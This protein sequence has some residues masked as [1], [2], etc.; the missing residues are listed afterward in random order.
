MVES[1]SAPVAVEALHGGE[2]PGAGGRQ[3]GLKLFRQVSSLLG[4]RAAVIALT[5]LTSLIVARAVGPAAKGVLTLLSSSVTLLS[6]VV[7]LGFA[8]GGVHLYKSRNYSPGTI[9]G[10]SLV[11][12]MASLCVIA[13]MLVAGGG[14]ITRTFGGGDGREV[15]TRQW[16]WLS[17]ATLPAMLVSTLVQAVMLVDNRM[18]VYA[19]STIGSQLIGFGAA[20]ALVVVYGWGI[21]GA[22]VA[23]LAGHVC[24]LI[25]SLLWLRSLGEPGALR[26]PRSAFRPILQASGGP[27][28]NSLLA[29][30]FKHGEGILLALLLDLRSVGHFGVALAFYQLLTEAPRAIVW[31]LVGRMTDPGAN[32]VE[33]AA[34]SLRLVPIAMILPVLLMAA[35]SP[36]VIPLVY[37]EAFSPAGTLLAFM[38][39]GV[40][41]RAVS[42]VVYAYFVVVGG[43]DKI[44]PCVGATAVANLVLDVLLAPRWGLTGVAVSNV[45][46]EF[47]LA[48]LSVIVFLRHSKA[49]LSS[50]LL[51]KS[52]FKGLAQQIRQGVRSWK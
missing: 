16:L 18:R 40:I 7:G 29:N 23:T 43:L 34:R 14:A 11:F 27:Y 15:L 36:F 30:V 45:I 19:L 35:V 33:V 51:R 25:V 13:M 22:L 49:P 52:D 2:V 42:L 31:P 44:A 8:A 38:S 46:A 50:I 39:P 28:L 6:V 10:V 48:S 4:A 24:T 3:P 12:W 1:G 9:G 41:L 32:A 20:V 5:F 26:A 21:T 47:L 37:G 17:F